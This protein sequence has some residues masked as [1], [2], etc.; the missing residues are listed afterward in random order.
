[1]INQMISFAKELG[2]ETIITDH[3]EPGNELP[4]AIAVVDAKRKDNK[5]YYNYFS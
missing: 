5:Y 4:E 1:M 3:H 2:I